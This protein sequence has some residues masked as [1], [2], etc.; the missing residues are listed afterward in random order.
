MLLNGILFNSEAWHSVSAEDFSALDKIDEALLR[1]LL[2]S[3]AKA[4]LEILYLESGAIPI[5]YMASN[6]RVNYLQTILKREDEELTK[7]VLLAQLN[8]PCEGDFIQL[9]KKDLQTIGLPFDMPYITSANVEQFRKLV[10][11]KV[12]QAA[13]QYLK[14]KQ[15]THTK[16]QN[17]HYDD[18]EAQNYLK[19]P[20]FTN[21][22]TT[23]LFSLRTR[24]SRWFKTNFRN[25]YGGQVDCPLKC[26][27]EGQLPIEDSQ[28][29]LLECKK[30]KTQN[31]NIARNK[32]SYNDLFCDVSKQKEAVSLFS[33]L[34]ELK[35]ELT[36]PPG[37]KLGPSID[38]SQC[39]RNAVFTSTACIDCISIG[40]K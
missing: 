25:L 4:P 9:V 26:W 7:R 18:L 38:S 21:E 22:D 28:Q 35:E 31:K 11:N 6:R 20:L 2:G 37:D 3:H 36:N 23:L 32:I 40:N 15:Q 12:K 39:C 29:H 16:V 13:F 5:R 8:D 10:K 27:G 30:L 33:D 17:I 24:T 34:I 14:E 19:S 1:F